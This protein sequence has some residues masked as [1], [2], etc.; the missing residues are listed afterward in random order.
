MP[1]VALDATPADLEMLAGEWQGEYR[2]AALGRRG[3]IDFKLNAD[4]NQAFGQVRMLPRAPHL[5][6]YQPPAYRDAADAVRP[7]GS[8]DVL[9]IRF[10]RATDGSITGM[11]DRYWDP[12]R[13]CYAM[14]VFRGRLGTGMVEGT[15]KT[16]FESGAGEATGEW[17]AEKKTRTG[18]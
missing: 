6:D 10:V 8:T 5:L 12:D 11:L 16:T 9:E 3:T 15:F 4:T 14:T 18:R 17:R 2:S 7:A 1:R 13:N